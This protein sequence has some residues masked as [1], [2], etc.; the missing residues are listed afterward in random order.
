M[1]KSK[2]NVAA[3][4][5]LVKDDKILLSLRQNTG[6]ED[7]KWSLVA[8]HQEVGESVM[9]AMVRETKEEIGIE[10]KI[11]NLKVLHVMHRNTNREYINIFLECRNWQGN[12]ENKEPSKCGGLKFYSIDKLPNNIIPYVGEAIKMAFSGQIYSEIGWNQTQTVKKM[13]VCVE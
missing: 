13:S 10:I 11:G 4:L 8:G 2:A 1:V 5:L 12:V 9:Q 6:Y 3:Y 7:N